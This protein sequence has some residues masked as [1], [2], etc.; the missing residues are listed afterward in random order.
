[1]LRLEACIDHTPENVCPGK[2]DCQETPLYRC[3]DCHGTELYCRECTVSYHRR[4]PL[5]K[6]RQWNGQYFERV[7]LKDLGLRIQLGHLVGTQCYL[8]TPSSHGDFVILDTLGIHTVALDYCNCESAVSHIRQL[9]RFELYP[10]TVT[11]PKS[12]ATFRVLEHFQ[13]LSFES[14]GSA[15]EYY[16]TISRLTDN[17]GLYLP[18][19]QYDALLRMVRQFRHLRSLKRSGRGHDPAGIE[20]TQEGQC[21]VICPACP[22]PGMNLP[23]G[24]ENHSS[25]YQWLYAL[26]VASDANFRMDRLNKSSEKTDPSLGSGWHYFVEQ[27]KFKAILDRF[28]HLPQEK[29]TC[30][31]HKAVNLADTKDSWGKAA[32]GIGTVDCARH[33]FKLPTSVGDLQKGERYVNMDHFFFQALRHS[34]EITSLNISYDIACQWNKNLKKRMISYGAA[35]S[36]DYDS[37][38]MAFFVPKFHLPAHVMSCQ[39]RFSFNLM[40][41]VGRTDGEAVERGWA[42]IN[43][44]ASST[45]EMGPG[46]RRDTLDDH[47]GDWNWK[48]LYHLGVALRKK[49]RVAVVERQKHVDDFMEFKAAVPVESV[50]WQVLVE[51]WEA[52]ASKPNPFESKTTGMSEPSVRLVLAQAEAT[53]LASGVDRSLHP[54]VPPSILV[55]AGLDLEEQQHRLAADIK[56]ASAH[57]TDTQ[58]AKIQERSNSLRRRIEQWV[59]IQLLYMPVV[60]RVRMTDDRCPDTVDRA[61]HDI[62]LYLPSAILALPTQLTVSDNLSNIE[63]DLRC[64]QASDALV[65][66]RHHIRLSSHLWGF[67]DRQMRGQI[68]NTRSRGVI[69]NVAD[70]MHAAQVRYKTARVALATLAPVLFKGSDWEKTYRVLQPDDVRG[71]K[72]GLEGESEGRRTLSWIWKSGQISEDTHSEGLLD[73]TKIE[74]CRARARANRWTEEV[75]LLREEMRRVLAFLDWHAAWWDDQSTRRA[76]G[77]HEPGTGEPVLARPWTADEASGAAAYAKRQAALRRSMRANFSDMWTHYTSRLISHQRR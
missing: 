53:E 40:K 1:M 34:P 16:R 8:S 11:D 3:S 66:L 39:T 41:G 77:M 74:W 28:A 76:V 58:L 33:N 67:K 57:A 22:Q 19:D 52:D 15:F 68:Q 38:R 70:K 71:I 30:A 64:A 50:H 31:G 73:A 60:A 17:C 24:W 18:K 7:T 51:N 36:F 20:G 42:N 59:K 29:S 75:L 47:F 2:P 72:E 56:D 23:D 25:S 69:D 26:F 9:L 46:S 55:S 21:A 14:K 43:P 62:R 13:M 10:A 61:A 5:H 45:R 54:D 12:A 32:T 27:T 63:W 65:S 44:A 4:N 37:K 6:I 48:K 49:L 35:V